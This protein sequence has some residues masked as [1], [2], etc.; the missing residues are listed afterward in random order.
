[1]EYEEK[2]AQPSPLLPVDQGVTCLLEERLQAFLQLPVLPA[3][4]YVPEGLLVAML[5][6]DA[7]GQGPVDGAIDVVADQLCFP[8]KITEGE[9]SGAAQKQQSCKDLQQGLTAISRL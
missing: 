2:A 9:A 3:E 1:V 4:A 8:F 7:T 5:E 6:V